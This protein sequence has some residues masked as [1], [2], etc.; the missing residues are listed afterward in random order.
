MA[1]YW[2]QINGYEGLYD[3]STLG[4]VLS[5]NTNRIKK[6]YAKKDR[7]EIIVLFKDGIGASFS[8]H[9]LVAK[10]FVLNTENKPEV[11]HLNKDKVDNR[12]QNLEWCTHS[13][14]QIHAFKTIDVSGENHHQAILSDADVVEMRKLYESGECSQMELA[15]IFGTVSSNVCKLVNYQRRI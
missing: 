2:K 1:E 15:K 3:V 13:E 9:S 5:H 12:V 4:Q 6:T 8:V 10:A 11:N 14:N 7:Y